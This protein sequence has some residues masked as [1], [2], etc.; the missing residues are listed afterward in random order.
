MPVHDGGAE[1]ARRGHLRLELE[2]P[3]VGGGHL[4][5]YQLQL[6]V[7]GVSRYYCTNSRCDVWR[8]PEEMKRWL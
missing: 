6:G 2:G 7:E 5:D 3:A 1:L 8:L 4:C